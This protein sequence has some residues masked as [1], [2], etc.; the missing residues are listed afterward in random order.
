MT[1][2]LFICLSDA[3]E[4]LDLVQS[5]L[6]V[7][8]GA[9]HDLQGHEL[10]VLQVP[11]EPDSAEVPPAELPDHVVSVVE[12]VSDLDRV[13]SSLAVVTGSLLLV[14]IRPEDLFLL[15]LLVLIVKTS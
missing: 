3:L 13:V 6:S 7:V 8:A 1:V 9:L 10:L 15:L 2:H 14:V 11:A 12:Q 5:S 4:K